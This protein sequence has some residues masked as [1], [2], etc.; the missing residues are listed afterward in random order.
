M[1]EEAILDLQDVSVPSRRDA[2]TVSISQVTWAIHAQNFWVVGGPH[3]AGKS[4]LIFMLAGLT[5]PLA[6]CY[7]LFGYDM[8]RHF[9]DE[10][11]PSRLRIGMVFDDSRLLSGFTFAENV[12][13]PAR[14][15]HN[16]HADEAWN[17]AEVLLRAVE[18][19]EFA[20]NKP[21]T[22]ARPWR[23]RAALARALAL[24]PEVLLLENPLRGM[25]A[26]HG[27]WWVKFVEKLS[28]GHDVMSGK[29]MT[30]VVS[31]D[32]F[33]PWRHSRAQFAKLHERSFQ[34]HDGAAPEDELRT[35]PVTTEEET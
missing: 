5:K 31:T 12:A 4:D 16:L 10:F 22:V 33:H 34:M 3:G 6:G 8:S 25:D 24:K 19:A 9:G 18:A 13:L 23:Q 7:K 29:P 20:P 2:E 26:R 21:S 17:W 27:V 11:L 30:I 1:N 28:R 14:Y 32:E 35:M 15:H